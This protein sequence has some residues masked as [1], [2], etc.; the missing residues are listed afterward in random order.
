MPTLSIMPSFTG[1]MHMPTAREIADAI[2]A[3]RN[4]GILMSGEFP[5]QDY[6][7]SC[8]SVLHLLVE[9]LLEPWI[10]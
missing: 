2:C 5:V 9:H 6:I 7:E 3:G 10:Q 8:P 4:T 1:N